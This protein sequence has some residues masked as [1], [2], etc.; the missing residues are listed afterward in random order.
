MC[1]ICGFIYDEELDAFIAPKPFGS[2][3]LNPETCQWEAPIPQ[4]AGLVAWH[5]DSQEWLP[6]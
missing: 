1:V 2:W 3:S 5:E 6:S 4:P